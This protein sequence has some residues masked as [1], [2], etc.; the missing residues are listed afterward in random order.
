MRTFFYIVWIG[1][2]AIF[3]L[4]ALW[5]KLEEMSGLPKKDRPDELFK[6]GG[7]LLLCS[8]VAILF[9]YYLL[10]SIYEQ[11]SPDWIPKGFYLLILLP[12]I[13]LIAAKIVGPSKDILISK[14][15][16]TSDRKKR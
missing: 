16:K 4:L 8:L 6:Q 3:F 5:S 15:P 12:V 13:L 2:P 1:L 14:A 7:F 11:F 10:D 9:D